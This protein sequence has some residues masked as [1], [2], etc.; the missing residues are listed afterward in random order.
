MPEVSVAKHHNPLSSE[1]DVGLSGQ[2]ARVKPIPKSQPP[3]RASQHE[4]RQRVT[5]TIPLLGAGCYL[6][7]RPK[8]LER[9]RAHS[10]NLPSGKCWRPHL[11][12]YFVR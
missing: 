4:F 3:K 9:W 7:A 1:D 8:V 12:G 6:R 11:K 2:V 5:A 10:R